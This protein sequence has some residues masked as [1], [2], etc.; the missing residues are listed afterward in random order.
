MR[1]DVLV[2]EEKCFTNKIILLFY[3]H[4]VYNKHGMDIHITLSRVVGN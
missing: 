1:N 3:L 2:P 4:H